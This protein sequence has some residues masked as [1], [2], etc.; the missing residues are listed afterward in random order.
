MQATADRRTK[1]LLMR[2]EGKTFDVIAAELGYS[3]RQAARVDFE[4]AAASRKAEQDA[5]VDIAKAVETEKL[6]ALEEAAWQVL[7]RKHL[8]VSNGRLIE[9]DGVPLEDDAP[10]L[11]AVDRILRV[12]ERRAKLHGYDAPSKARVEV[13]NVDSVDA[14]IRRLVAE[15][16]SRSAGSPAPGVA[17]PRVDVPVS[18]STG[19]GPS[20]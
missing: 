5:T 7:R 17:P 12:A 10:V 15:L 6:D 13:T 4:R 18:E 3:S 19:A 20:A 2:I 14:D 11:N 9:V 1:N 8:T 16:G